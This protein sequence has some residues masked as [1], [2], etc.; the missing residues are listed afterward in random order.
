MSKPLLDPR[1]FSG[2]GASSGDAPAIVPLKYGPASLRMYATTDFE[3]KYRARAADREPWTVAWLEAHVQ[4]GDVVFDVGANVGSFALIAATRVGAAGRVYAF[5]PGYASYARLC[6]NIILNDLDDRIVPVPM[7]LAATT[8]LVSFAYRSVHAGQS[9]HEMQPWPALAPPDDRRFRQPSL[10][11]RLDDL[12]GLFHVPVPNH[13]KL[14]VDGAERDVLEGFGGL[15]ADPALRSLL[16]EIDR[17][18][19]TP[20]T[21]MLEAHGLE[22]TSRFQRDDDQP[23]WYGLFTRKTRP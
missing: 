11:F 23:C 2:K 19:T 20:I 12:V 8:S 10:A 9:R 21:D 14:D 4:P 17:A 1:A 15:L 16:V 3:R 7:P 22:L 5:E 18:L 6:D 13:V